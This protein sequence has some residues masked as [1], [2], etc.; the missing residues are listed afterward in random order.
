M[1]E[2]HGDWGSATPELSTLSAAEGWTSECRD[3]QIADFGFDSMLK[4]PFFIG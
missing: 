2:R 4:N 3:F 1:T